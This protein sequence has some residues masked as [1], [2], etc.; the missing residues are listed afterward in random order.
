M[1]LVEWVHHSERSNLA[2]ASLWLII[3]AQVLDVLRGEVGVELLSHHS[4][5]LLGK[6]L[7]ELWVFLVVVRK[8]DCL[9]DRLKPEQP[10]HR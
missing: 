3:L 2:P 4:N 9:G 7:L 8:V 1:R 5:H 6:L 10:S